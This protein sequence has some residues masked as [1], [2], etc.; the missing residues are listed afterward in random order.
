MPLPKNPQDLATRAVGDPRARFELV[1]DAIFS[2]SP[3]CDNAPHRG[4]RSIEK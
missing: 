1:Q 2:I 4:M 3:V